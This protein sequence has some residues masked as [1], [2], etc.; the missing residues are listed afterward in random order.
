MKKE[1]ILI[2]LII[3]AAACGNGN[4][5]QSEETEKSSVEY[6]LAVK[7]ALILTNAKET[8]KMAKEFLS[9]NDNAVLNGVLS[10][11]SSTKDIKEQRKAFEDLS[12]KMYELVKTNGIDTPLYKQFCP[13]AFNNKGAFWLAAEKEVNNPYF[14]DRMLHCGSVK[15]V[16]GSE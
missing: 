1:I 13:M 3:L 11:I 6:Y 12:E 7:D 5:K 15:E 4:E 14:G 10:T 2:A 16:L 9:N 8:Q